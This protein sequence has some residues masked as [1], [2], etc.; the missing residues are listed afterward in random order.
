MFI[1]SD[2]RGREAIIIFSH[3]K[4]QKLKISTLFIAILQAYIKRFI[5]VLLDISRVKTLPNNPEFKQ[6]RRG[7]FF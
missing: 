4:P 2:K 6:L 5:A 3:P 1:C 7:E